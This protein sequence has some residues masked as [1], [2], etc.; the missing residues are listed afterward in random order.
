MLEMHSSELD[1]S[2]QE[3]K[4]LAA[5]KINAKRKP[6]KSKIFRFKPNDSGVI[7]ASATH[8]FATDHEM[9]PI[10]DLPE[11]LYQ[12]NVFYNRFD[13]GTETRT[14]TIEPEGNWYSD[15]D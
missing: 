4:D 8:D 2:S 6:D 14:D 5:A 13:E 15:K 7:D 9:N 10:N 12:R 1:Q 11:N 3:D